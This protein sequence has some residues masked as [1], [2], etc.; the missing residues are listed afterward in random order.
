M[1]DDKDKYVAGRGNP[2]LDPT[3]TD[4]QR[5]RDAMFKSA[6]SY[7]NNGLLTE[8]SKLAATNA[9]NDARRSK[10]G[11]PESAKASLDLNSNLS[12]GAKASMSK[13]GTPE[14]AK[15]S[16]DLDSNLSAAGRAARVSLND[17]GSKE[18]MERSWGPLPVRKTKQEPPKKDLSGG[19]AKSGTTP[20]K[21]ISSYGRGDPTFKQFNPQ[22]F[23]QG[24]YKAAVE[25]A[26]HFIPQYGLFGTGFHGGAIRIQPM[27]WRGAFPIL[28]VQQYDAAAAASTYEAKEEEDDE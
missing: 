19:G 25:S 8:T 27:T 1:A 7:D 2:S 14:S 26:K 6:F 22:A 21:K 4:L 15:A 11:T 28:N 17:F 18:S 13:F 5:R 23:R 20:S 9:A 3:Q 12:A 24:F 16:L 10:F